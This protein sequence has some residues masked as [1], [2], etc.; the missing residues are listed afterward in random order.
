MK[1]TQG[2]GKTAQASSELDA[3]ASRHDRED[4]YVTIVDRRRN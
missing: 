1:A 3:T 2:S 4:G